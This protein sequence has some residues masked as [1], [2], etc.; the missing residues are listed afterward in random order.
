MAVEGSKL[1]F[2]VRK[3]PTR[4]RHH[5]SSHLWHL[6]AAKEVIRILFLPLVR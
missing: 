1:V 6:S 4:K 2:A 3:T 5:I